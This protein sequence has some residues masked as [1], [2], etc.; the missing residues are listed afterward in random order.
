MAAPFRIE[1]R[2]L[3]KAG[4]RMVLSALALYLV[5][6]R[7][8]GEETMGRVL[9]VDPLWILPAAVAY[10]LSHLASSLRIQRLWDRVPARLTFRFVVRLYWMAMFYSLFLPGGIAGD[11]YKV[12]ILKRHADLPLGRLVRAGVLDRL[13]GLAAMAWLGGVVAVVFL[14]W[15]PPASTLGVV[16]L[17]VALPVCWLAVRIFFRPFLPAFAS[18]SVLSLAKQVLQATSAACLLVGMG[19][20]FHMAYP[21]IFL[22]SSFALIVPI[23]YGG[24]GAREAA[25]LGLAG[26]LPVVE[27]AAVAMAFAFFLLSAIGSLAGILVKVL[28]VEFRDVRGGE[29]RAAKAEPVGE[30]ATGG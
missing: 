10:V 24:A 14:P 29:A 7:I 19:D 5:W 22:L 2:A 20:P 12:W 11:G 13:G 21:L 4:A 15:K 16:A 28:P 1:R 26:A 3:L 30:A 23:F 8:D 25:T 17:I 9:G 6:T 18:L 27:E